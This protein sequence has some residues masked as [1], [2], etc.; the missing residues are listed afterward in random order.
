MRGR[1]AVHWAASF[2]AALNSCAAGVDRGG[3]RVWNM[4]TP[5]GLLSAVKRVIHICCAV[6]IICGSFTYTFFLA[7]FKFS[8]PQIVQR[9]SVEMQ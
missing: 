1:S 8:R 5:I 2:I 4:A 6:V 3:L 7:P 9:T